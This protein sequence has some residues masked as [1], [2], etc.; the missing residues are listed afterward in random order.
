MQHQQKKTKQLVATLEG[1]G[2]GKDASNAPPAMPTFTAFDSTAELFS[3]HW[4][5]FTAFAGAH[6]VPSEKKAQVFLV[7]KSP[8]IFELLS[9]LASL[10]KP[11]NRRKQAANRRD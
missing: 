4:A 5:R 7:S 11:P 6:P 3:D 9:N 8:V 10:G 2:I 1:M